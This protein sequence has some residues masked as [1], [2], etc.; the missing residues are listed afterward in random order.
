MGIEKI[1]SSLIK[2]L[3]LKM[4]DIKSPIPILKY[5]K[6]VNIWEQMN[7]QSSIDHGGR[8]IKSSKVTKI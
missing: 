2:L 6:T 5:L 3:L 8:C 1:E 4:N 7:P